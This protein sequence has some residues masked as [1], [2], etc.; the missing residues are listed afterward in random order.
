MDRPDSLVGRA[1]GGAYICQDWELRVTA[2]CLD[3]DLNADEATSFESIQGLEIIKAFIKDRATHA[4]A[5]KQI[6]PMSSGQEI[7]RLAYGHDH[8]GATFYDEDEAVIWLVAYG[9]HRSGAHD[10]F[11]PYCKRLDAEERLLP[12]QADIARM[13]RERD[14]RF[15]EAVTVE[16]PVALKAARETEGEYRCT[17]G[18][19]LGAGL[20]IEV[21]EEMDATSITV[22]FKPA[23]GGPLTKV[24][25]EQGQ[26]LLQALACGKWELIGRMPSRDLE[27]EEVAFTI[28]LVA[29]EVV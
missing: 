7:G 13:Y 25:M 6:T 5:S 2:R 24:T 10:D 19:E 9:R 1:V 26:V 16:A 12:V 11:F 3:E 23:G 17:I 8:R 14:R 20:A 29:G 4:T 28:T 27:P 18:G 22:A 21:V 15:V